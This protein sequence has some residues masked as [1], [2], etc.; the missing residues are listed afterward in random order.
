MRQSDPRAAA[1]YVAGLAL[2]TIIWAGIIILWLQP[3][4]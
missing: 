2:S 3:W 4:H 1:V